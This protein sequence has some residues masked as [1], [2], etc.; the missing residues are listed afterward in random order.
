LAQAILGQAFF[1][2]TPF[3]FAVKFSTSYIC[4]R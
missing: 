3:R 4:T 2:L 1:V